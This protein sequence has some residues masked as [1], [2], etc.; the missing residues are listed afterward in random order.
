[1]SAR[2]VGGEPTLTT[3]GQIVG[4]LAY[5][6]PEQAR[7][8]AHRADGRADTYSLGVVLYRLLT[9]RLP[10]PDRGELAG[11]LYAIIHTEPARPRSLN[12]A[13]PRDLETICLK[14]LRR[15][16]KQRYG[17]ADALAADLKRWL[18]REPIL[19]RPVG[20][21]ERLWRWCRRRPTMAALTAAVFL[22][23]LA[24]LSLFFWQWR[25][26]EAARRAEAAAKE[27]AEQQFA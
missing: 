20:P 15:E 10:F 9:G 11:Q 5:L 12:P 7:G 2:R 26:A 16:P 23:T 17:S 4:T 19:A 14:C 21:V 24:G 1:V 22:V 3:E 18:G 25:Q 13:V 27:K 8:G 6:S